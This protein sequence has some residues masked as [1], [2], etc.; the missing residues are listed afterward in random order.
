MEIVILLYKGFTPL[1]VVG[2]Y[3]VLSRLPGANVKFAAKEKG[4]IES[5]NSSLKMLATHALKEITS[6]DILMI[7][8]S[9]TAFLH[10]RLDSELLQQIIRIDHTTSW[11]VAVCTGSILL[12]AAG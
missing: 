11:T 7:P 6:A 9:T 1:D 4:I 10:A 2:P 12:A 3:E 8:G 5:E